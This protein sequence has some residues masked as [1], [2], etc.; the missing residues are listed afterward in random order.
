MLLGTKFRLL[1]KGNCTVLCRGRATYIHYIKNE[2]EV[3]VMHFM[4]R[5]V[6]VSFSLICFSVEKCAF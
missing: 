2:H 3:V 1:L 6:E 4:V 5:F